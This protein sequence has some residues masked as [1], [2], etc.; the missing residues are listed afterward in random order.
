MT[1]SL[2]RHPTHLAPDIITHARLVPAVV[3][4]P[5]LVWAEVLSIHLAAQE[6]VEV[7]EGTADGGLRGLRCNGHAHARAKDHVLRPYR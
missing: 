6:V 4:Q 1:L 2:P 7:K 5:V 3:Q